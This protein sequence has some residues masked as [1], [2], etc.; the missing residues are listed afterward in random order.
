MTDISRRALALVTPIFALNIKSNIHGAPHWARVAANG[1]KLAKPLKI[2]PDITEWFA[3]LH[4]ACRLNDDRDPL[5][6]ARAARL[7]WD[8]KDQG[9]IV[10]PESEFHA[11]QYALALHSDG[12]QRVPREIAACWDADRLDLG[13]V[14]VQ[15]DPDRMA[16][17]PGRITALRMLEAQK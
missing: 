1:R 4:D 12:L 7:A 11:L 17:Y 9:H 8:F 14:N 6:G 16:S 13:R 5:H 3:Y 2:N 10:L 15:P